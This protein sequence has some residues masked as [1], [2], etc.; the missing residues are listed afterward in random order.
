[1][2]TTGGKNY[3]KFKKESKVQDESKYFIS[4]NDFPG[5]IYAKVTTMLGSGRLMA[6]GEDN[7]DY[8]CIIRGR[9]YKKTWIAKDDFIIIVPRDYEK[10]NNADVMHKLTEEELNQYEI[11]GIF[12]LAEE[13]DQNK[14][15]FDFDDL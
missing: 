3:K 9:L 14:D 2:S 8:N 4:K 1:M 15:E 7:K 6:K 5:S 10:H 11:K 13:N 12:I